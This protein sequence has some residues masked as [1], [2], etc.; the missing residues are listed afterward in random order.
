VAAA[1]GTISTAGQNREHEKITRAALSFLAPQTLDQIAGSSA[2]FGAVGAPDNPYAALLYTSEAHCDDGDFLATPIVPAAPRYPQA[3]VEARASLEKCKQWMKDALDRAIVAAAP[4]ADPTADDVKLDCIF[5]PSISGKAKCNVLGEL[6]LAFHASQDFYSHTNWVDQPDASKPLSASNPPG[7]GKSGP[8]PWLNFRLD[9]E[10]FP[11]GLISG[12][13]ESLVSEAD[14]CKYPIGQ[15][16]GGLASAAL[17]AAGVVAPAIGNS[18]APDRTKHMNLN[19]DRGVI[20]VATGTASAAITIS[21]GT[22]PV[23]WKPGAPAGTT[24]RGKI[25]RNFERAVEAAVADTRDHWNWFEEEV[26]RH[27]GPIDGSMIVCAMRRDDITGCE[28]RTGQLPV[29]SVMRQW[30]GVPRHPYSIRM[31]IAPTWTVSRSAQGRMFRLDWFDPSQ[32]YHLKP[33]LLAGDWEYAEMLGGFAYQLVQNVRVILDDGSLLMISRGEPFGQ[34]PSG[35]A[36]LPRGQHVR[37]IELEFKSFRDSGTNTL[38]W[39]FPWRAS[40]TAAK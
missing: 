13:F 24:D 40:L 18:L 26:M 7:L 27:Y 37:R 32:P 36:L 33:T 22:S 19:K 23:V 34:P 20:T 38:V 28:R 16:V 8:A 11:D 9:K 14:S 21:G 29:R 25:N 3:Y 4:L 1:F 30:N 5:A 17:G 12:C 15:V 10:P 31:D 6:G 39:D 2:T 35:E